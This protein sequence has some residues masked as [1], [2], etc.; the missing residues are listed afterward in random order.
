[1]CVDVM[2]TKN[3]PSKRGS[4]APNARVQ[5]SASSMVLGPANRVNAESTAPYFGLLAVFGPGNRQSPVNFQMP[6]RVLT[7]ESDESSVLRSQF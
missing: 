4:R 5:M 6:D 1:M 3:S 2:P 7:Y